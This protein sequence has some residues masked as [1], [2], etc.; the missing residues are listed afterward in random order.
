MLDTPLTYISKSLEPIEINSTLNNQNLL[1]TINSMFLL[2]G[3]NMLYLTDEETDGQLFFKDNQLMAAFWDELEEE[4]ALLEIIKLDYAGV[5]I[6]KNHENTAVHFLMSLDDFLTVITPENIET[7]QNFKDEEINTSPISGLSFV[8][9]FLVLKNN[10]ISTHE[11]IIPDAVPIDYL[12]SLVGNGDGLKGIFLKVNQLQGKQS[13]YILVRNKLT[14]IFQLKKSAE[15]AK[16]FSI[17][18]EAVDK[19]V[20]K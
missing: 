6:V 7:V 9:G 15:R 10:I 17:L 18:S 8:K 16:L 2:A 13:Y 4:E 1:N 11:N 3:E 19:V 20:T 5:K 14:W 12:R